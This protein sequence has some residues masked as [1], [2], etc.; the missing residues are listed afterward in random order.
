MNRA[1]CEVFIGGDDELRYERWVGEY[2]SRV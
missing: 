1:S 2:I